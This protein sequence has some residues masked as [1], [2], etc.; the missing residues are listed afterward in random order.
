MGKATPEA[1]GKLLGQKELLIPVATTRLLGAGPGASL[2][3]T[4]SKVTQGVRGRAC[5]PQPM[6]S[7]TPASEASQCSSLMKVPLP[8]LLL[9]SP[10]RR[11]PPAWTD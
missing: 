11:G 7:L 3:H 8:T 5:A 9:P 10:K 6:F 2:T 4:L 1:G